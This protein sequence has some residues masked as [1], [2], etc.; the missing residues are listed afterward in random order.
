[1]AEEFFFGR[2]GVKFCPKKKLNKKKLNPLHLTT[3]KECG[4]THIYKGILW[5]KNVP[6]SLPD[7]KDSFFPEIARFKQ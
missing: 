2:H 7:F 5:K 4:V 1:L 3:K 6:K